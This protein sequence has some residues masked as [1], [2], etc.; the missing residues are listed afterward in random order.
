MKRII[1]SLIILQLVFGPFAFAKITPSEGTKRIVIKPGDTLWALAKIYL[2]DPT[3]WEEF[4]K[5]NKFTDPDLIYPNEELAIGYEEA[6]GLLEELKGK[7]R[8]IKMT[9]K[10]KDEYI[11]EMIK[12][13]KTPISPSTEELILVM[14]EKIGEL[15][16]VLNK[17][18]DENSSLQKG[19][20]EKEEMLLKA[21][22]E[23]DE[24]I[25]KGDKLN[26]AI[27]E[28]KGLLLEREKEL[29]LQKL[30]IERLKLENKRLDKEKNQ[31][32]TFSYFLTAGAI[33]SLILAKTSE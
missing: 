25:K 16:E 18:R 20:T 28:L 9:L 13:L 4:K 31:I 29:E 3:K 6:K 21:I 23:R 24:L 22:R 32:K 10:E 26:I 33:I 15:E 11:N 2:H 14:K 30:E 5:Y 27:S 12:G 8:I 7:E 17:I 19:L 1:S